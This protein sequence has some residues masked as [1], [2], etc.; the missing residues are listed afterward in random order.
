MAI[1]RTI[2]KSNIKNVN[3]PRSDNMTNTRHTK[4]RKNQYKTFIATELDNLY[5]NGSLY[6]GEALKSTTGNYYIQN[7]KLDT[8][9]FIGLQKKHPTIKKN[10][11]KNRRIESRINKANMLNNFNSNKN[12]LID[13]RVEN[14]MKNKSSKGN[15]NVPKKINEVNFG[16]GRR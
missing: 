1:R 10:I 11:I 8:Y 12:I 9:A 14:I 3:V 2:H 6:T 15:R 16:K 13:K 5:L 7:P 4:F